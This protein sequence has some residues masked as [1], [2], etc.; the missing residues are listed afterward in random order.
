MGVFT[1]KMFFFY[2]ENGVFAM[3]MGV[4]G[5]ITIENGVF[6]AMKMGYIKILKKNPKTSKNPKI[7]KSQNPIIQKS[8]NQ[9]IKYKKYKKNQI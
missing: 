2:Y 8:Q 4:L 6:F 7:P 9:I 1:M 3:E 5:E